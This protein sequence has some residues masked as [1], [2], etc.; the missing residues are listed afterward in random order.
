MSELQRS[1]A[2]AKLA[3]LPFNPPLPPNATPADV[4]PEDDGTQ[5][6]DEDDMQ[7]DQLRPLPESILTSQSLGGLGHQTEDDSSS[8]SSASSAS[9]TGTVR[10]EPAKRLFARHKRYDFFSNLSASR[11]SP[12]HIP[13]ISPPWPCL[14]CPLNASSTRPG[15]CLPFAAKQ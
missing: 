3:G 6:E 2:R 8:A 4:L 1:F 5:D 9:S 12:Q 7:G 13:P 14:P 10:P 15:S 11:R